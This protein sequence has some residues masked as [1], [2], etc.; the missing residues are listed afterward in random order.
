[1]VGRREGY[2]TL[3]S[4]MAILNA[5]IIINFILFYCICIVI[6]ERKRGLGSPWKRGT[7][8]E[9]SEGRFESTIRDPR[10]PIL[11]PII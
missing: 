10:N 2:S 4:L 1:M 9:A 6:A 3:F 11:L 7:P 5:S 8:R